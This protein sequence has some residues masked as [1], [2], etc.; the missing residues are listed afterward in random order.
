MTEPVVVKMYQKKGNYVSKIQ[1][2]N[3]NTEAKKTT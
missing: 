1:Q 3:Y 2:R